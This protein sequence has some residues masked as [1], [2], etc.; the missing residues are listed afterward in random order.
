MA[1]VPSATD[2]ILAFSS[3]LGFVFSFAR[4]GVF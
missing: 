2:S 3:Y 1:A 4:F